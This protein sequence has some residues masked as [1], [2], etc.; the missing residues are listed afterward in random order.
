MSNDDHP[1]ASS[2][3]PQPLHASNG[4][5]QTPA[6]QPPQSFSQDRQVPQPTAHQPPRRTKLGRQ[7]LAVLVTLVAVLVIGAL[8]GIL[9]G[10]SVRSTYIHVRHPDPTPEA[11]APQIEAD[12]TPVGYQGT[13]T[14]TTELSP[15]WS[16]GLATAWTLPT[17][18]DS[19]VPQLIAEGTTLFAVAHGVGANTATTVTAYDI[20][21]NEPITLWTT[22][23]PATERVT[24]DRTP[25]YVS[26]DDQLL[27]DGIIVDKASGQ[28]TLAPWGTD[29]PVGVYE[30]NLVT[31]DTVTTCAGWTRDSGTWT[32]RWSSTTSPQSHDGLTSL[33]TTAAPLDAMIGSGESAS[34]LVPVDDSHY[35][36]KL[37]DPSN[38][39][40]HTLGTRT[41]RDEEGTPRVTVASD[42]VAIG[43]S[44][45]TINAYDS[46]GAVVDTYTRAPHG[47][48]FTSD[49][50]LPTLE[51]LKSFY[52]DG[53]APWEVGLI[54]VSRG[55][56]H[57]LPHLH[58][59]S[60]ESGET[61]E[62]FPDWAF[63][64]E[65]NEPGFLPSVA[66]RASADGTALYVRGPGP[67]DTP[68]FVFAM[69]DNVTGRSQR[70]DQT[71]NQTWV[72]DDLLVGVT[73]DGLVAFTPDRQQADRQ[74]IVPD[75][76]DSLG[77]VGDGSF[78]GAV[79]RRGNEKDTPR[80]RPS[81][82][83]QA[84]NSSKRGF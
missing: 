64:E 82:P 59:S 25:A 32:Q 84:W 12:P 57:S 77:C 47:D 52:T 83:H 50:P 21:D 37:V 1:R 79:P 28:Q 6:P 45:D 17:D 68:T 22:T 18:P 46:S 58:L 4:G 70:L 38:G 71:I 81:A 72:Y 33:S 74:R 20:S 43:G 27:I 15:A 34:V 35:A 62:M 24:V 54:A 44:D 69:A 23:G 56:A 42:G 8:A 16:S 26:T 19:L 36:P 49:G 14:T 80:Q 39:Q 10:L 7:V 30:G 48:I 76:R 31:C 73:K 53:T 29:L 60:T 61:V 65:F 9:Y 55:G 66:S 5:S 63:M 51:Q 3:V 13:A 41:T 40:V 75:A 11:T 78:G 67:A 2:P